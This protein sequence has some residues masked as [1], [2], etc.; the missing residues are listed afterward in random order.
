MTWRQLAWT[1][2]AQFL[3]K[4]IQIVS[5]CYPTPLPT[6]LDVAHNHSLSTD[7][8]LVIADLLNLRDLISLIRSCHSLHSYFL[9]GYFPSI[10]RGKKENS[11]AFVSGRVMSHRF[12]GQ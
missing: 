3:A 1:V 6:D 8:A 7:I 4:S 12:G 5:L 2:T 9:Q 11:T 10:I